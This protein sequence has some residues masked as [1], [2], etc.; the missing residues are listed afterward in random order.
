MR[1]KLDY[2]L[3]ND[4]SRAA[5][6]FRSAALQ[7]DG[8]S[9]YLLGVLHERGEGVRKDAR[10]ACKWYRKAAERTHWGAQHALG[11]AHL[12]GDGAEKDPVEGCMWLLISASQGHAP[13]AR[14]WRRAR[15]ALRPGEADE[16]RRRAFLRWPSITWREPAEGLERFLELAAGAKRRLPREGAW[17]ARSS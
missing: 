13:A 10:E 7:N 17:L 8:S 2:S 6:L 16:V 11:L 3:C 15:A 12:G 14:A 5:A 1:R 9:Y 4:Y